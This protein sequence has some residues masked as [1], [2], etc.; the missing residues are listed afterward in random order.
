M[1]ARPS[2]ARAP[3]APPFDVERVRLQ[4]TL[5]EGGDHII[6]AAHG[7]APVDG[8]L[9]ARADAAPV[10]Q[11]L[12]QVARLGQPALVDVHERDRAVL[13]CRRE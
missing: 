7:G 4:A 1:S 2:T 8:G 5:L 3:A 11:R 13:Q 12:N 6:G 10:D 9:D